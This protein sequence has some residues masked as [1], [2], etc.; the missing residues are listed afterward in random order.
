MAR[1][2]RS[3][4]WPALALALLTAPASG[5]RFPDKPPSQDYFVDGANLIQP[6][7]RQTINGIAG[8]LLREHDVP[9]FVVTI[10]SLSAM[11]AAGSS[12]EAYATA[13][14]NHWGIG[15]QQRNF[16][17]LLLV[18]LGDRKAR[19]EL[20]A[21]WGREHDAQAANIMQ[22]LIIPAFK[23]GDYS[24]GIADGVRGL[25]AMVRGMNLPKPTAP[26]WYWPAVILGAIG[27]V[28][29]IVNLFRTGHK[30]WA[31]ALIAAVAALLFFML[32]NAGSGSGAGFGGGSSGGGGATGSW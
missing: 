16:G 4:A 25:D 26:W 10:G 29:A 6:A 5:I 21:G 20:G 1:P 13:L 30:G 19:I 12:I 24:I 32:R 27:I 23:R 11:D 14:F 31:W 22:S 18:S 28:A 7:Q 17:V 8:N 9:I 15:S 3:I 2:P